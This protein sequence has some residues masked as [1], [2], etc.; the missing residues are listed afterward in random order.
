MNENSNC[1]IYMFQQRE[2][3]NKTKTNEELL[4]YYIRNVID[5]INSSNNYR[6][7]ILY[8]KIYEIEY[9]TK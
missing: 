1:S 3:Y 5:F 8:L 7:E 2:N 9:K 4:E 6:G